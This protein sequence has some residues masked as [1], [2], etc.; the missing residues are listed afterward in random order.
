MY[1]HRSND[2]EDCRCRADVCSSSHYHYRFVMDF[3]LKAHINYLKTCLK[4]L[5]DAYISAETSLCSLLYFSVVGLDILNQL[6]ELPIKFR[7][8]II[9]HVYS[10]Q[11]NPDIDRISCDC[12]GFIGSHYLAHRRRR[13]VNESNPDPLSSEL[14]CIDASFNAELKS[15]SSVNTSRR[16]LTI[17]HIAMSYTALAVLVTLGDDLSRVDR[18]TL[19]ACTSL[20]F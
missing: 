10:L 12:C 5:P 9:E 2:F 20:C 3:L 8:D 6:D 1:N 7:K 16:N 15:A 11:L 19:I 4:E 13:D 14:F 18:P 17:G